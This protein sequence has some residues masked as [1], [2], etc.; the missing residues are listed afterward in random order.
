M[1]NTRKFNGIAYTQFDWCKCLDEA[2][3]E[4]S[5][6]RVEGKLARYTQTS[7]GYSIWIRGK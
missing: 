4:A 5:C 6:L 7:N 1:N 3:F 2:R